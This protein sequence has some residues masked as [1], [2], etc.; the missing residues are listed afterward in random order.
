MA[1]KAP[2]S[3]YGGKQ[4]LTKH[5]L[6]H[7][8]SHNIFVELFGGSGAII[9]AKD[10]APV[11][12]YNDIYRG[13]VNFYRVLR[14]E[15]ASKRLVELLMLTPYS[16]EEYRDCKYTWQTCADPIEK[17]R[18]WYFVQATSYN[19]KHGAG[20][21]PPT[22]QSSNSKEK[23][24]NEYHTAIDR[25]P[26]VATR[27]RNVV[28]ENVDFRRAV[29]HYD[30]PSTVFYADPPY[31]RETRHENAVYKH[32]MILQ[33]HVD[34]VTLALQSRGEWVISG[35]EHDV[36][37]PLDAHGWKRVELHVHASAATRNPAKKTNRTEVLWVSQKGH[38]E[39]N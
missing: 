12:V 27:L 20:I 2:F 33:D 19:G 26:A 7:V 37:K 10:P 21:R 28:I 34:L 35:Y 8:Q 11:E 39:L 36:Y 29:K 5:I 18:K 15:A 3:Y 1:L 38:H 16:R 6:Q 4:R 22:I 13:I 31:V 32:E 9:L 23:H 25:I 30:S 24:V 17:A 14:D